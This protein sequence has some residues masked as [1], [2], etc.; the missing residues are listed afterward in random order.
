MRL[1]LLFLY[2][3][4]LLVKNKQLNQIRRKQNEGR[5][6]QV[7]CLLQADG[8]GLGFAVLPQVKLL[9]KLFGQVTMT[10]LSK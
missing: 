4:T 9:V 7:T 6:Q 1:R 5:R 10:A 8:I 2:S 3:M